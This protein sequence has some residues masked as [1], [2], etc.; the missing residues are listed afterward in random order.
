MIKLLQSFAFNFKLRPYTVAAMMENETS[1]AALSPAQRRAVECEVRDAKLG[2]V[3]LDGAEKERYNEIAKEL[4]ALSTEFSNNVLDATKAFEHLATTK[5]EVG[6]THEPRHVH[7]YCTYSYS[8]PHPP[9]PASI[10]SF[11]APNG[12][13]SRGKHFCTLVYTNR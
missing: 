7:L 5:D 2:G 1:W 8:P 3:A 6:P 13:M 11:V 9:P 12:I 10:S 4:S